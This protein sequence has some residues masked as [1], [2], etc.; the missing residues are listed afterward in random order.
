LLEG[1]T[2]HGFRSSFRDWTGEHTAFPR[3]VAEAALAHRVGDAVE[4][5]YRRGDALEKRRRLMAAWSDFCASPE[6]T[7]AVVPLKGR[8]HA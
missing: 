6:R 1:F 7:G 8:G 2:L 4:L 5:A 3:E